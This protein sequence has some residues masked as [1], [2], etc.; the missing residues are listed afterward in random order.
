MPPDT[1]YDTDFYA[2]TQEQATLLDG[3]QW[4]AL[5]LPHLVEEIAD[6]GRSIEDSMES[7]W[8]VL[9][10]HLLKWQYQ[11]EQ[12]SGSRRGSLVHARNRL[13]RLGRKNPSLRH[14][15]DHMVAE[16]YPDAR[17][18]AAAET[19]LGLDTFPLTCPWTVE[20]ALEETF[21]PGHVT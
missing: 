19:G 8:S 7:Y 15:W 11:P 17:T 2:W 4:A 10:M 21:W 16:V 20:Q 1:L 9:L 3:Q 5:D 18:E 6:L 14:R 13:R 12:R